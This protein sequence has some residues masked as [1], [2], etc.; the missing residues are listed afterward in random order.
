MTALTYELPVDNLLRNGDFETYAGGFTN[1]SS[2]GT[3]NQ[4]VGAGVSASDAAEIDPSSKLYQEMDFTESTS[5]YLGRRVDDE[6][7]LLLRFYAKP[8]T[9][10]G[11]TGNFIVRLH[12]LDSGGTEKYVYDWFQSKWVEETSSFGGASWRGFA[13]SSDDWTQYTLPEIQAPAAAGTDIADSDQ[14]RITFEC[15]SSQG[16][17]LDEVEIVPAP[18]IVAL[19]LGSTLLVSDGLHFPF[20]YDPRSGL[21]VEAS[22][23]KPY[24]TS[25]SALPV[26]T[27][28]TTGSL[29]QGKYY[30]WAHTHFDPDLE[31]ES[32]APW[33]AFGDTGVFWELMTGSNDSM[34]INFAGVDVPNQQNAVGTDT[35]NASRRL[36][37]RTVGKDTQQQVID[38]INAGNFFYVGDVAVGG[39]FTDTT[40]DTAFTD[41]AG[42]VQE[43]QPLTKIGCPT[44]NV[45]ERHNN[46][47]YVSGGPT[48]RTGA[49][50]PQ[51]SNRISGN[52]TSTP[53]SYWGRWCD[54]LMFQ[55]DGENARY[56]I[57]RFVYAGD[58]TASSEDELFLTQDYRGSNSGATSYRIFPENGK[59][60]YCEEGQPW[61]WNANN[62]FS[63]EG[64][65]GEACTMLQSAGD[66]LVCATR[67]RTFVWDENS[68]PTYATPVS[69][70][71]GCIAPKSSAEVR[72]TAFW[73]SDQGVVRR[74]AGQAL[75]I[76]SNRIQSIFS[77]QDDANYLRRD[78]ITQ[79]ASRARGIDYQERDQYL[80]A[81]KSVNAKMGCDV[82]LAYNYFFDSWDIFY[83]R[84]E[85]LE[86]S[87]VVDDEGNRTLLFTDAYGV[88]HAWDR[89]H[90]DGAGDDRGAGMVDGQVV[91]ATAASLTADAA[92]AVFPTAGLGLKG[93]TVYIASGPGAGQYR[94]IYRNSEATLYINEPWTVTPTSA[95]R[96]EI[97]R[98]EF[99]W[100]GKD[101][102][103][104]LPG[105]VKKMKFLNIDHDPASHGGRAEVRVFSEFDAL[106]RNE[107]AEADD[108][109]EGV[110][111]PAF[112]TAVGGR[113]MVSLQSAPGYNHRLQ[114]KHS[115][116][117]KPLV[118]RRLSV[119]YE[120]RE[121]DA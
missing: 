70:D 24:E 120:I 62:W 20:R 74:R 3:I 113:S 7:S 99:E 35:P 11:Y 103:L 101:S 108:G 39:T 107:T 42:Y 16:L 55:F 58:N 8:N 15:E 118:V 90:V 40:A 66:V 100:N 79:M 111:V 13:D 48:I 75:E 116:P 76:I 21:A 12:I 34:Q 14:L 41:P 65:E 49:A 33:S 25:N 81:Y 37:Y 86:W 83:L 96:F 115:G 59:V 50:S 44:F 84:S 105:R 97:G 19:K 51:A 73:L 71:I 10:A 47:L 23:V 110:P 53:Y 56:N 85:L 106:A 27:Q 43:I 38:E 98:I 63:L 31:E 64:A 4:Q 46:R 102:D 17:M 54:G 69:N 112:D 91:S 117:E 52:K 88:I 119:G 26:T 87:W 6:K 89:G 1:W 2:T 29:S 94:H 18:D 109:T 36:V 82:V 32:G 121:S 68:R 5:L 77:D 104:G 93:V 72:G 61:H 9:D 114:I 30:G 67:S 95:S 28:G 78:P 45:G 80:L 22:L 60:W 92:N 57:Q